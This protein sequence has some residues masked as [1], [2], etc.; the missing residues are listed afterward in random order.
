MMDALRRACEKAWFFNRYG[1][2]GRWIATDL[3]LEQCNYWV[4]VRPISIIEE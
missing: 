2:A 3:Y 1:R 4:K